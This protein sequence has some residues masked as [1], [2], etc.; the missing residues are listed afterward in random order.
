ME[1]SKQTIGIAAGVL[2]SLF[3]GYCIYFDQKRR[4]DPEYKK[5]VKE[6]KYL[7]LWRFRGQW[8]WFNCIQIAH[9][10][11]NVYILGRRKAKNKSSGRSEMPDMIDK[12]AVQTW[13]TWLHLCLNPTCDWP[14]DPWHASLIPVLLFQFLPARSANG[15][16]IHCPRWP[17]AGGRA[18]CQCGYCLWPAYATLTGTTADLARPSVRLAYPESAGVPFWLENEDGRGAYRRCWWAGVK[19]VNRMTCVL[20]IVAAN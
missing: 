16:S 1:I 2:G 13:V 15:R 4:A 18:L 5:K 17:G 14:I 7:V 6:R 3:V 11:Q 20:S 8:Q 10:N 12:N 19:I 9:S